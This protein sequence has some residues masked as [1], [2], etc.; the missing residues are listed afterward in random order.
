VWN[1]LLMLASTS[2]PPTVRQALESRIPCWRT[3]RRARHPPRATGA[4]GQ[5]V[6]G[7]DGGIS[8]AARGDGSQF[9]PALILIFFTGGA[10]SAQIRARTKRNRTSP[11]ATIPCSTLIGYLPGGSNVGF[12]LIGPHI[13]RPS[14]SRFPCARRRGNSDECY[15]ARY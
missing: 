15:F 13:R 5:A 7:P 14:R 6:G 9:K 12:M 3:H 8:F 1:A 10:S 4:G 2:M 11:N